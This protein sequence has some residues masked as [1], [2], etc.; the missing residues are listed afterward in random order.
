M[1]TINS[2]VTI[3]F[4]YA[5]FQDCLTMLPLMDN[6]LDSLV[7]SVK[8]IKSSSHKS[9]MKGHVNDFKT[10]KKQLTLLLRCGFCPTDSELLE[11]YMNIDID[12][13]AE[14]I[15]FDD[16]GNRIKDGE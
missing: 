2:E 13:E 9:W 6:L 7:R 12:A 10:S 3:A 1:K 11:E 15:Q 8:S 14:K 16:K 5:S 4:V